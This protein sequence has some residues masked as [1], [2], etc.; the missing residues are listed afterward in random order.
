MS[1][2]FDGEFSQELKFGQ[3][4]SSRDPFS[5]VKMKTVSWRTG[6][7]SFTQSSRLEDTGMKETVSYVFY[8]SGAQVS[9]RPAGREI[10]MFY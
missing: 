8:P 6:P 4:V 10:F 2:N 3:E 7:N 9:H 1:I 5:G